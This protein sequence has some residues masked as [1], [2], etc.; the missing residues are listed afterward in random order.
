[1]LTIYGAYRSRAT[2]TYWLALELGIAFKSVPVLQARRMENPLAPDA[3]L[4]TASPAFVTINPMG[5][6]PC[7]EDDGRVVIE[8]MAINL[9]LAKKHG[10]TLSP[11]NLAED[12]EMTM[13]SFFAATSIETTALR[14]S[15][16]INAGKAETEEGKT[17]IAVASRLLQRPFAVLDQ[18]LAKTGFV[19]GERFTVAD[20]NVAEVIRYAQGATALMDAY[21]TLK[22]WLAKV[23]A[24]PAFVKM[25][26]TREAEPA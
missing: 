16:V 1:M 17:E 14:I 15:A 18:H 10:G 21:P 25:W 23:Q 4:N 7:I 26:A 19:V 9:Y 3:P 20:L 8:S 24:R 2:R 13:W 12:T 6:I 11:A 5:Q 22:G